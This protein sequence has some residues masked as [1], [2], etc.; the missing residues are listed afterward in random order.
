MVRQ[1]SVL[2]PIL[3]TCYTNSLGDTA[4]KNGI[5]LHLYADDAQLYQT[6]KPSGGGAV[7]VSRVE[8]CVAEM[9]SR[10]RGNKRQLNDF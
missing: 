7:A 8:D 6:F 2:V 1:D 9:R 3:L 5:N 10:M 4:H